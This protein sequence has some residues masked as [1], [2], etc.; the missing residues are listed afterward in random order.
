MKTVFTNQELFHVFASGAQGNATIG[1]HY[2]TWEAI[3]DCAARY[4]PEL[5]AIE[6]E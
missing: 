2:L 3:K 6:W 5:V 4:V 1:C